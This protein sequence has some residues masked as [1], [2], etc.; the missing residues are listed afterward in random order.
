MTYNVFGVTLNL[1]QSHQKTTVSLK[2]L[3]SSLDTV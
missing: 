2:V 1:N 3:E